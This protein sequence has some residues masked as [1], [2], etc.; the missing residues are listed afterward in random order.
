MLGST[1]MPTLLVWGNQDVVVPFANLER[2]RALMPSAKACVIEDSGHSDIFGH[3]DHAQR[4]RD[5][6]VSFVEAQPSSNS[7][8][9]P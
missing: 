1:T 7:T 4:V 2:M 6:I 9:R 5:E 3:A 8:P